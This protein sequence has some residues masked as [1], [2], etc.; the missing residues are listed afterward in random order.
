MG[1]TVF[2]QFDDLVQ[3]AGL[4]VRSTLEGLPELTGVSVDRRR[5]P[6][7]SQSLG[8]GPFRRQE[9]PPA[10]RKSRFLI[11]IVFLLEGPSGKDRRAKDTLGD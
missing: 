7:L 10:S 2:P 3:A 6:F 8:C 5:R 4:V 1:R 11:F 9:R